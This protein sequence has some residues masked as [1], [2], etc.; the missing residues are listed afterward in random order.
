MMSFALGGRV[1]N[2]LCG[3]K[4]MANDQGVA[5]SDGEHRLDRLIDFTARIVTSHAG[6]TAIASDDLPAIIGRVFTALSSL[7]LNGATLNGSANDAKVVAEAKAEAA[8]PAVPISKS[9]TPDALICL[10]DGKSVKLL[11]RYLRTR[12]GMT[13]A[14]YRKK[15]NL[16][17][18]YPMVAPAYS[19][20][21]REHAARVGFKKAEAP[22]V[23]ETPKK[24]RARRVAAKPVEVAPAIDPLPKA[25]RVRK[26]KSEVAVAEAKV[27]RSEAAT[28]AAKPV[29]AGRRKLGIPAKG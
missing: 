1:V 2:S 25:R 13:A 3:G 23:V 18:S 15:W 28:P 10:E 26:A 4:T 16:P 12:F 11:H 5:T 7:Q 9:V 24:P 22:A 8:K 21:R 20:S 29:R 6:N 14:E 27:K 17:S 19:E